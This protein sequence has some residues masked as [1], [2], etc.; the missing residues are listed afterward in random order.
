MVF[1]PGGF[2]LKCPDIYINLNKLAYVNQGKY[3]GVIVWN[4]LKDDED[5]F[6]HLRD[7]Y[8]R[9]NNINRKYHAPL[10]HRC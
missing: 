8:A 6:R 10:F 5:I 3:L 9:S 2:H 1:K 4:D 7:V